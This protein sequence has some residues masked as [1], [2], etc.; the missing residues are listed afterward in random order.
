MFRL[1]RIAILLYILAFFVI[2]AYVTR[3][4]STNWEQTLIVSVH[5]IAGDASTQT[6]KTLSNLSVAHFDPLKA[7]FQR[8]AERYGVKNQEVVNIQLGN[9]VGELPPALPADD[10]LFGR[11]VWGFKMRFWSYQQTRSDPGIRPNVRLFVIYHQPSA[12]RILE[13]SVGLQKGMFGIV[14]A[15]A[16]R[17]YRGSNQLVMAHELLHT[18]GATDKYQPENGLPRF[19]DGFAEPER[20]PLFPQLA[21]EVMGGR[22]PLN[23]NEAE[24]PGSLQQVVI[25]PLT[26]A[27]IRLLTI[28]DESR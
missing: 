18:L 1:I 9:T 17:E 16:G 4:V 19:P 3:V 25:G 11:I 27:E 14:H 8:E 26:A 21:T 7:F 23:E 22:R 2:G 28:V 10:G 12:S 13:T 5:P 20:R 15:F 24:I 6:L